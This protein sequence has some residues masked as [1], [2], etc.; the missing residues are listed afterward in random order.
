ME[1]RAETNGF[2]D[3]VI[4]DHEGVDALHRFALEAMPKERRLLVDEP[5]AKVF[6]PAK[7][8]PKGKV[9]QEILPALLVEAH[10][11]D[12]RVVQRHVLVLGVLHR[13]TIFFALLPANAAILHGTQH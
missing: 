3:E 1:T 5:T 4:G 9:R 6:G 8:H 13:M 11:P 7:G 2:H 12:G 10:G